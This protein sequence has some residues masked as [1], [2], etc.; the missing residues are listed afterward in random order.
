MKN[1]YRIAAAAVIAGGVG[2]ALKT[3]FDKQR[4]IDI[5]NCETKPSTCPYRE[6]QFIQSVETSATA[7]KG[8]QTDF[9]GQIIRGMD[10]K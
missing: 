3:G 10:L 5:E 7:S 6:L 1:V 4:E 9:I 8:P 2:L